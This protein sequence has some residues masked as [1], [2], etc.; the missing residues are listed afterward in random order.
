MELTDGKHNPIGRRS[1]NTAGGTGS[2][3]NTL[4][5]LHFSCVLK[6]EIIKEFNINQLQTPEPISFE[7]NKNIG[8]STN[9]NGQR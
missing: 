5:N 6:V 9:I 2:K 4:G 3:Q 7:K 1:G 8:V